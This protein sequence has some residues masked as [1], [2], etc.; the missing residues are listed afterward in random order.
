[1]ICFPALF[2]LDAKKS[3]QLRSLIVRNLCPAKLVER[4]RESYSGNLAVGKVD[5]LQARLEK[6]GTGKTAA[7][8]SCPPQSY[9]R[10]QR[11]REVTA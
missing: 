7:A 6:F 9:L 11:V 1:M 10:K 4:I 5:T 3:R 2:Y 8:E